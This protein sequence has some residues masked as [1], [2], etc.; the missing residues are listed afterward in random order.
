MNVVWLVKET[1]V[2]TC[3]SSPGSICLLEPFMRHINSTVVGAQHMAL[4]LMLRNF[5]VCASFV[6][7][8]YLE[9]LGPSK[10]TLVFSAK[11]AY[12]VRYGTFLRR[13]NSKW[14]LI[15]KFRDKSFFSQCDV[16][17]ELKQQFLS[18][19]YSVCFSSLDE[20]IFVWGKML[21]GSL[22]FCSAAWKVSRPNP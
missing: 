15:L 16:C 17:Q 21:C 8:L 7:V 1:T 3:P 2:R 10:V 22:F 5:A 6:Y 4:S 18:S 9:R 14:T 19:R 12:S 11:K 20:I 13:W